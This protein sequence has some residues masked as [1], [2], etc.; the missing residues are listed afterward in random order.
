V[1]DE[2]HEINTLLSGLPIFVSIDTKTGTPS[3]YT[4]R[5]Q[6]ATRLTSFQGSSK[7]H[8]SSVV[9]PVYVRDEDNPLRYRGRIGADQPGTSL[10]VHTDESADPLVSALG[11]SEWQFDW[12]YDGLALAAFPKADG[13][14]FDAALSGGTVTKRASFE[15][16]VLR[17]AFTTKDPAT[18][19]PTPGCETGVL[20]CI[21]A[22]SGDD[23]G[24]CGSYREVS[25]C[26]SASLA[27]AST[28]VGDFADH[29]VG[30]YADHAADVA[31]SGGN[32][33]QQAQQAI[34]LGAVTE[35]LDP[36]EDP[37]G[38]DLSTTLV[39]SHPDVVFPGS[40]IVWFGAYDRGTGELLEIYDFN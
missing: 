20:S 26:M 23:L 13:V 40:D 5:I 6:L 7:L 39:F 32:T 4:A 37:Y 28:F 18:T 9:D 25:R 27:D 34:E 29:L 10:V 33:L 3:R 21:Q 8:P 19:W 12:T 31:A 16:R 24:A 15:H 38:H 1:L 2:G 30:W 17:V 14:V 22:T 35:L 11:D 36:S